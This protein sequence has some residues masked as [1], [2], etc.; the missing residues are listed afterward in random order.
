VSGVAVRTELQAGALN[1]E[2][3]RW[4]EAD[5]KLYWVD[6]RACALHAFDPAT[7]DDVTW[8]LPSWVGCVVLAETSAI[9]ALRTGLFEFHFVNGALRQLAHAPYDSRRFIFN[10]G[11]CDPAG[12]FL[13]GEMYLPLAPGDQKRGAPDAAPLYRYVSGTWVDISTATKTSNGLAWSPDGRT[14][15]QS[16]TAAGVIFA[17]NYDA[18]RG[19]AS[20][21]RIFAEVER[22]SSDHGPDG[23][24]VDRD[25]FYWTAV[26]GE[27][28]LLR[29]DP[30]GRLE[31]R[32]EMP[33]QYPTMP[34]FG[35]PDLSTV[36]V[37]S[38]AWPIAVETRAARPLEGGLF[39]FEAP[40]PG[41]ATPLFDPTR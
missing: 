29:F 32:I 1:G 22:T 7:Q 38:A 24:A 36:Y 39:S 9:V 15:Y 14:M 34:A 8:E 31:R 17:S 37:T 10:D 16:D 19:Q 41:L 40:V 21:R 3:P 20:H 6:T 25:G 18:E 13:V 5:G 33:V 2:S 26:F 35:G 12:R 11:G 4:R 30:A 27:G 28:C 23:A